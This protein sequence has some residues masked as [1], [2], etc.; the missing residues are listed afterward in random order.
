MEILQYAFMQRA[1]WAGIIVGVVCPLIGMVLVLR[2]L[3]LIGDALAHISLAG[4]AF[5]LVAGVNPTAAAL[6]FSVMGTFAIECLYRFYRRYAELS[7]AIIIAAGMSLAVILISLGR[8]T[9]AT[10]L[11]FLF[12]SIIAL[13][14]TDVRLI[15]A[16]GIIVLAVVLLLYH[17]L[18]YMCF[19]EEAAAVAGIPV[20]RAN[21]LF[22]FL[23]AVTVAISMRI[24]GALLVSSLLTVPVAAG[25]QLARSFR[26]AVIAS[27]ALGLTSVIIGI[28]ISF[29][30][31]LPPGATI[32][33]TS[34]LLLA[35]ALLIKR[36][37]RGPVS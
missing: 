28:I 16:V 7:I 8:G 23:V 17:Q 34:L 35:A 24:V 22:T 26:S 5:G 1:I 11:S 3:S 30:L 21:L 15:T 32:I 31:N 13:N 20:T 10:V 9:T 33:L 6:V 18:F 19:D 27:I 25:L 14:P 4:V 29:Y 36:R 12:G 37:V 2:R